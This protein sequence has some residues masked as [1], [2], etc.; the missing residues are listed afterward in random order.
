MEELVLDLNSLDETQERWLLELDFHNCLGTKDAET[1]RVSES[2]KRV[3]ALP[4]FAVK[5]SPSFYTASVDGVALLSSKTFGASVY[6]PLKLTM[7]ENAHFVDTGRMIPEDTDAVIPI[8]E[9][10]FS[11]VDEVEITRF[12]SPW[13]NVRPIGEELTSKELIIPAC[14]KI[15]PLDIAA[16]YTG[17]VNS[18]SVFR[19]PRIG[20][21]PIGS[22]SHARANPRE[23]KMVETSAQI[24]SNTIHEIGGEPILLNLV[25]ETFEDLACACT[26]SVRE[27]DLLLVVTGKSYGTRSIAEIIQ[28]LGDLV[29]YGLMVKPGMT[30]CFGFIDKKP[31]I[32]F[33]G[34]AMST[35]VIF[36]LFGMPLI[37]KKLGRKMTPRKTIRAYLS[38]GIN[39]HKGVDEFL[40]VSIANVGNMPVATPIS[41]GAHILMS[42][43]RADGTLQVG[44][45]T[46]EIKPGEAVPVQLLRPDTDFDKKVLIAGT[47]DLC[48]D[49][50]RNQLQK[51]YADVSMFSSNLGSIRGLMSLKAGYSHISSVHLFDDE[52]GEFNTPFVRK[53]LYDLPLI[54]VNVFNRK[55]GFIVAHGNPKE[56]TKFEDLTRDD[57]KIINRIRGS[58]TR[59]VFDYYLK[60]NNIDK[61]KVEGYAQEAHNHLNLA[62]AV[63]SGNADVG[64]GILE[65]A[66]ATG[67]DFV[68]MISEQ[69]DFVVPKKFL[70]QYAVRCLLKTIASEDFKTNVENLGGYD[71]AKT[72]KVLFEI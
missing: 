1:I 21:L 53:F 71:T 27:V 66:R 58:G 60:E 44:A 47:Y 18:L 33:S 67:T 54:L 43:V 8:D 31:V 51:D 50:L 39:S 49:I 29:T 65:A 56:I 19:K 70:K 52:T 9:V 16:M 14:Q 2:L 13:E 15:R 42:L 17:G 32:G 30:S 6:N 28:K 40:R 34:Y 5:P 3:T 64:M 68:P 20:I 69:L 11:P 7:G 10:K 38:Q 45:E 23:S 4:V 57:V 41:R 46:T 35:L 48:F 72:G 55:L 12:C 37:F 62:S 26:D 59:M 25:S 36:E 63:A 24:L 22:G 61:N